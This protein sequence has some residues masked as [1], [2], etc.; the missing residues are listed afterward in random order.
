MVWQSH[1]TWLNVLVSGTRF[2]AKHLRRE[3]NP[4][5]GGVQVINYLRVYGDGSSMGIL[6]VMGVWKPICTIC[7]YSY[8]LLVG[9]VTSLLP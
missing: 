7:L 6:E 9:I 2:Y 4:A 3:P 5:G 8:L 1:I